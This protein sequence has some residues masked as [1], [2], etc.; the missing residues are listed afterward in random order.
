MS[1]LRS[2]LISLVLLVSICQAKTG[3]L[4]ASTS[5]QGKGL[6]SNAMV[7]LSAV[8]GFLFIVFIILI[9]KRLFFKKDNRDDEE[10]EPEVCAAFENKAFEVE[11]V[12]LTKTTN[13]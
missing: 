8:A 3:G 1:Y 4:R 9:I 12:E 7:G 13:M 10:S 6:L 11:T 5:S 2:V